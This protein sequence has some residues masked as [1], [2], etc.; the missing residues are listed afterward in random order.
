MDAPS[1]A[2]FLARLLLLEDDPAAAATA[3]GL[4]QVLRGVFDHGDTEL[5]SL[6]QALVERLGSAGSD[7]AYRRGAAMTPHEAGDR[8]AKPFV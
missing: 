3:L 1:A 2:R 4:S 5:R 6:V 7:T 8:L